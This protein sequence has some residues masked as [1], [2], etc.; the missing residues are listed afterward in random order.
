[1]L[2][3]VTP[4]SSST[5]VMGFPVLLSLEG[6]KNFMYHKGREQET[7][8]YI[9][10]AGLRRKSGITHKQAS[11]TRMQPQLSTKA[12]QSSRAMCPQSSSAI[13]SGFL[14]CTPNLL[15]FP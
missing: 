10:R 13:T 2:G 5:K 7:W 11:Q 8:D 9:T 15:L 6:R 3:S 4:G 12:F 1:M 14:Q